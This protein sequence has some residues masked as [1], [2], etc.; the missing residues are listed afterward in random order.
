MGGVVEHVGGGLIDGDGPGIGG[1][2][3]LFLA[4][5]ELKGFKLIVAHSRYLFLFM[6]TIKNP[7]QWCGSRTEKWRKSGTVYGCTMG[8]AERPARSVREW[9]IRPQRKLLLNSSGKMGVI[10]IRP[11]LK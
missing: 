5:V 7:G 4:Y 6:K 3:G 8:A 10:P 11:P 2:I 9:G 1:G